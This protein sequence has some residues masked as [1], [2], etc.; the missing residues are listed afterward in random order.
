MIIGGAMTMR[1]KEVLIRA[2]MFRSAIKVPLTDSHM[3]PRDNAVRID[4]CAIAILLKYARALADK[5]ILI[6]AR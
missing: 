2:A 3:L 4:N 5:C 1:I 6:T